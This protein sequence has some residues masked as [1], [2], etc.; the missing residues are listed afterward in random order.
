MGGLILHGFTSSLSPANTGIMAIGV[1]IGI[2]S[3][4]IP[5]LTGAAAMTLLL[6]VTYGMGVVPAVLLLIAIWNAAVWAGAVPAIVVGI[7]G[8]SSAAA[9]L[10]DGRPLALQGVA[11]RA[12]R[13][14]LVG[15][16]VGSVAA[17]I[18]LLFVAPALGG[19]VR[20][21]GPAEIFA[22]ATFGMTLVVSVTRGSALNA[23]ISALIGLFIGT[24]GLAPSGFPRFVYTPDMQTGFSMIPMLI[25]LFTFP[26]L[27]NRIRN[28]QQSVGSAEAIKRD[29]FLLHLHD[30]SAHWFNFVRSAVLGV[31]MGMHPGAG[32]SVASF[33][34]YNEARRASKSGPQF[35]EGNI[36]G[37]IAAD[38]GANAAVLSGLMPAFLLG[39][40]GSVDTVIIIAALTLH[41]LEPGPTLFAQHGSL[42]YT[43][44]TGAFIANILLLVIG[45]LTA[46]WIAK[47]AKVPAT[48]LVPVVTVMAL[49]GAF[50]V[51]DNWF[52]VATALG[53]GLLGYALRSMGVSTIPLLLGLILGPILETNLYQAIQVYG[54]ISSAIFTRPV[55][56]IFLLISVANLLHSC[57]VRRRHRVQSDVV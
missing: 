26:E 49:V 6:P 5:G 21:L 23:V 51:Q 4:S 57:I 14:S 8:T 17:A 37:V 7:P 40:P 54:S 42:V 22:F 28:G 16:F 44:F 9:T 29:M 39:I 46:R 19:V 20:Y 41:G 1:V 50:S 30:W 11:G 34:T 18:V 47:V 36:D 38:T 12:L 43:I 55:A 45:L 25:G 13:A 15:A 27:M 56:V 3:G 32:P 48:V 35:G 24:I 10:L 2:V 31:F 52:D 53:A 33:V